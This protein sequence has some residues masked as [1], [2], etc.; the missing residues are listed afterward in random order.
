MGTTYASDDYL[1]FV[2]GEG[3]T[4]VTHIALID[5]GDTELTGGD[6]AYARQP[7]TWVNDGA[8]LERPD[9]DL[10]FNI[11]VGVDVK[12]WRG[13]DDDTAGD[14]W[15]G[16]NFSDVQSYPTGGT[17]TLKADETGIRKKVAV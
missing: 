12:G 7:V 3:V 16:H 14:M 11:P 17:L 9:A 4:K 6:P 1:D 10:T 13:W 8:G 15:I 5:D 2:V